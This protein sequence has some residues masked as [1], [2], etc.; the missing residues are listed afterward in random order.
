MGWL[1]FD[2]GVFILV[3]LFAVRNSFHSHFLFHIVLRRFFFFL[4]RSFCKLYEGVYFFPK[5]QEPREPIL[6]ATQKSLERIEGSHEPRGGCIGTGE[7]RL[8]LRSSTFNPWGSFV[9]SM[10]PEA[11][12]GFFSS[13][14]SVFNTDHDQMVFRVFFIISNIMI[15]KCLKLS[16]IDVEASIE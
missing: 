12:L 16:N 9:R 5:Y 7:N 11:C 8:L 4:H 3:K 13:Y 14:A 15:T 1:A 2:F 10:G 6:I